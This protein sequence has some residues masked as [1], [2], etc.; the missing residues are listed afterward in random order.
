MRVVR[1]AIHTERL[2]R[3]GRTS[4]HKTCFAY[5]YR[6]E[7]RPTALKP[8]K[9]CA[10]HDRVDRWRTDCSWFRLQTTA[11]RHPAWSRARPSLPDCR[12]T[13][14]RRHLEPAGGVTPEFDQ[15]IRAIAARDGLLLIEVPGRALDAYETSNHLLT[16][17]I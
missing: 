3:I 7:V 13:A 2:R 9:L 4:L 6:M 11:F 5:C 10:F 16:E 12:C 17:S 8:L 15:R 1:R 14:Q